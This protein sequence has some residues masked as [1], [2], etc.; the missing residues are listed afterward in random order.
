MPETTDPFAGLLPSLAPAVTFNPHD[1]YWQADDG[2]VFSSARFATVATGDAEFAAWS[3]DNRKPTRWPTDD[4]GA[5]TD[6]ALSDVLTPYGIAISGY[7]P[8]P[9]SVSSAQAKIQ[10]QRT[11][12]S[13]SGKTLLDDITAAVQAAGGEAQIWFTEARA[14]E[15]TNPYVASLSS[16]LKLTSAQVDQLFIAAAQI[17]A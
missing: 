13:A 10:C 6:A 14:W 5:Q 8:V 2:R 17:A 4:S 7:T 3:S 12:G 9:V 16:G 1:W 15:R 11:P